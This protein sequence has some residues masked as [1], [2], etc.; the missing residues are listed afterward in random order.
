MRSGTSPGI[1]DDPLQSELMSTLGVHVGD[2]AKIIFNIKQ[3]LYEL[4]KLNVS[5][6]IPS[7]KYDTVPAI[8]SGSKRN[9]DDLRRI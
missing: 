6:T 9:L 7:R 4:V 2:S 5:A 1:H 8:I 3:S